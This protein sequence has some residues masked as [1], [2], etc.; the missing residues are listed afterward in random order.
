VNHSHSFHPYT[1]L[2][3][4]LFAVSPLTVSRDGLAKIPVFD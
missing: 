2:A 1:A 3:T 4:M